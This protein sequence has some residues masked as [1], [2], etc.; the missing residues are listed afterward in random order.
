[1]WHRRCPRRAP[2]RGRNEKKE[3]VVSYE[4]PCCATKG[5]DESVDRN[6]KDQLEAL[7][8]ASFAWAMTCCRFDTQEAMD[9]LQ[10]AYLKVIDGRAAFGGKASV[11]TW[12]F[13]VVRNTARERQRSLA[14]LLRRMRTPAQE[15][16]ASPEIDAT[17]RQMA[18]RVREALRALPARQR[19]V[20]DLVFFH[21]L[22]IAEA[23]DVMDVSL[24][25]ARTHYD[26]GKKT[27]RT[28]L[29]D[30]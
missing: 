22:T 19:E 9:V 7:H 1:M 28:K 12:W 11:K 5:R 6:L 20:L 2:L 18:A 17:A 10:T 8:H 14:G 27:L 21:D 29:S 25:T 3:A 23:A 30:E 15:T 4:P 13:S 26:R 16:A 24:G